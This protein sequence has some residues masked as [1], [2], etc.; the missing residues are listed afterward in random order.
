MFDV[1][2]FNFFV[3]DIYCYENL[4]FNRRVKVRRIDIYPIYTLNSKIDYAFLIA[5]LAHERTNIVHLFYEYVLRL[6]FK[7]MDIHT[8]CADVLLT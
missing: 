2:I 8:S 5:C 1:I 6:F 4:I 7:Y 3:G